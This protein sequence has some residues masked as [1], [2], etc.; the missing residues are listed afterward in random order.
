MQKHTEVSFIS[1]TVTQC[2]LEGHHFQPSSS[3]ATACTRHEPRQTP[4]RTVSQETHN[5]KYSWYCFLTPK[6]LIYVRQV[7][8]PHHSKLQLLL[9]LVHLTHTQAINYLH[10]AYFTHP[11]AAAAVSESKPSEQQHKVSPRPTQMHTPQQSRC[12]LCPEANTAPHCHSPE[13]GKT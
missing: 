4:S 12:M 7:M 1:L 6:S 9:T 10:W 3:P 8:C 13:M 11:T 5:S 2:L